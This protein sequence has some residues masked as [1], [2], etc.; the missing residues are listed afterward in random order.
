MPSNNDP[1]VF[2]GRFDMR[3][4]L[5]SRPEI[6]DIDRPLQIG[7]EGTSADPFFHDHSCN[8][9]GSAKTK[10]WLDFMADCGDGFDPSYS[11]SPAKASFHL[12]L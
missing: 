9:D 10:M 4:L 1:Q 5:A 12:P 7:L 3:Q 2:S 11:P 8:K 6:G